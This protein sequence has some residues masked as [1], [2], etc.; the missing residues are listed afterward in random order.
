MLLL[1]ETEQRPP[2]KASN[3]QTK[4]GPRRATQLTEHKTEAVCRRYAITCEANF[5]KASIG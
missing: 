1:A 4:V 5:G 2:W 3:G